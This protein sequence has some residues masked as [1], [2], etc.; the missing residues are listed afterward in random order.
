MSVLSNRRFF[1]RA[2]IIGGAATLA[3]LS[4]ARGA[5]I[6][7]VFVIALENHNF[8]QPVAGDGTT[9]NPDQLKGNPAAPYLNSL[10]ATG[11]SNAAQ[12]SYATNYTNSGTGV[13]PSEPNYVWAEAGSN[14]A[15]TSDNDPSS[16]N[17]NIFTVP[18]LTA[19]MNTAGVSWHNY[20]EDSQ[21]S[22]SPAI[23]VSGTGGTA[24]SGLTVVANPYN[25]TTQYS[26]GVKH[27]P[28]AFFSDTQT[29]NVKQL[30]QLSTDLTNNTVGRY[31]WITPD[32][33]NE[34]HSSLTGGF[35]YHGTAYTGD[36]A[37][38]AEGDNFLSIIIPQIMVSQAYQ[39]NGAIIIWS[40]ETEGGDTSA[41][42]NVE[43]VISKL[44]KGNAYASGVAMNHS[45]DVK[46]ME[47]IFGLGSYLNNAI[48]SSATSAS[49][50]GYNTVSSVN[51]LSD[52]F[53]AG[54]IPT[55]APEPGS[56]ALLG[57]GAAGLL[58]RRRRT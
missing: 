55:S 7:D 13:H 37:A 58:T 31:N 43:I 48:P 32:Q 52:L 45:S 11:N 36:Q 3:L 23:S 19:Q 5:Q 16:A 35:T 21:Y 42:T 18:H 4:H 14:L 26:Y 1:K 40:D 24:P 6:G 2:V 12:V 47:E 56:L 33:Y 8:T 46:T 41:F 22:T 34:M 27:N 9:A 10:I 20:Q 15:D 39:N 28:M 54:T 57:I 17:G 49:G 50:S 51:D 25:G 44:A 38:V 30:S 29:E 53:V